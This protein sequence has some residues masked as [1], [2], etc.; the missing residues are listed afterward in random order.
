MVKKMHLMV[1]PVHELLAAVSI[2]LVWRSLLLLRVML[3]L[4]GVLSLLQK[5]FHTAT[6]MDYFELRV[7]QLRNCRR[8]YRQL[9]RRTQPSIKLMSQRRN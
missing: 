9:S 6:L 1:K 2:L 7:A 4:L 3:F 8:L 5:P